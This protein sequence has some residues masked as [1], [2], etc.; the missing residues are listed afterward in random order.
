MV[1]REKENDSLEKILRDLESFSLVESNTETALTERPI[2]QNTDGP[3]SREL[4]ETEKRIEYRTMLQRARQERKTGSQDF[5][6]P[7]ESAPDIAGLLSKVKVRASVYKDQFV[8]PGSRVTLILREDL[9]LA[10]RI[11]PKNTFVYATAN[12][13]R[14]RLMM[15]IHNIGDFP[16]SLKVYDEEDGGLGIHNERAGEL[17]REFYADMEEGAVQEVSRELS[18]GMDL[19][20]TKNAI[21][22]FGKF[23]G[24]RKRKDR[25]EIVLINGYKVYLK[26]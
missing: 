23:F 10:G 12:I 3:E 6:A 18:D 8:V 17:L 11:F 22:V 9:Q 20:M 19:P 1:D 2:A 25:D 14:S 24:E 13:Q 26:T 15:D 21:R 7:T 4:S 5:S 16:V